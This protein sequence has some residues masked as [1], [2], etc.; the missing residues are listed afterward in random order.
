M[1]LI[2]DKSSLAKNY[3]RLSVA[4][5]SEGWED[6]SVLDLLPVEVL[7]WLHLDIYSDPIS[8]SI[9]VNTFVSDLFSFTTSLYL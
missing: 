7:D 8:F 2:D 1:W 4:R 5:E 9:Y 3:S 6:V